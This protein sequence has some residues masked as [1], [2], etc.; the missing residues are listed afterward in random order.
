[1]NT[2]LLYTI[3]VGNIRSHISVNIMQTLLYLF[4][5][6]MTKPT[7]GILIALLLSSIVSAIDMGLI[8]YYNSS[9]ATVGG[10]TRYI[11]NIDDKLRIFRRIMLASYI[12][13][14][15]LLTLL[16]FVDAGVASYFVFTGPGSIIV[17]IS[18]MAAHDY[19][20]NMRYS[21]LKR[22][23]WVFDYNHNPTVRTASTTM[24]VG[25]KM[26]DDKSQFVINETVQPLAIDSVFDQLPPG[27]KMSGNRVKKPEFREIRFN[28]EFKYSSVN[29]Y[30]SINLRK[31]SNH[32][33][34]MFNHYMKVLSNYSTIYLI[35]DGFVSC[36]KTTISLN[37]ERV[38]KYIEEN[39]YVKR[40]V[41]AKEAEIAYISMMLKPELAKMSYKRFVMKQ[42]KQV[43]YYKLRQTNVGLFI[44]EVKDGEEQ[45]EQD[46]NYLR[47]YMSMNIDE[48][49]CTNKQD[50]TEDFNSFQ[51]K[52][53]GF[54]RGKKEK[55]GPTKTLHRLDV[56]GEHI[57]FF[58]EDLKTLSELDEIVFSK[59][60]NRDLKAVTDKHGIEE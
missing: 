43:P 38:E 2:E 41:P 31:E 42:T 49:K 4:S 37:K 8:H 56:A 6:D 45:L 3:G 29:A 9:D 52:L 57:Y 48:Y 10:G 39:D 46:I 18:I 12:G 26:F 32:D 58:K 53:E 33:V 14:L 11:R 17:F 5:V 13:S 54:Q 34:K 44:T 47:Q 24:N 28:K 55:D 1:M 27:T 15:V 23:D 21:E 40:F 30:K 25:I 16:Y 22:T 7:R 60:I 35:E 19:S 50:E 51:D 59:F 20:V 36:L